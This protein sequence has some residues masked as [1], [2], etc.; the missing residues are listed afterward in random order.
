MLLDLDNL[1]KIGDDLDREYMGT[2]VSNDDPKKLGRVKVSITGLL[3]GSEDELPFAQSYSNPDFF[4]VPN[5]GDKLRIVFKDRDIYSPVY[6]G[7]YHTEVNHNSEFDDDYPNSLGIERDGFKVRYNNN[8]KLLEIITPVGSKITMN[9]DGDIN[10]ESKKDYIVDSD[11]KVTVTSAGDVSITSDSVATFAGKGSTQLGDNSSTT[12]VNGT[13]I[14]LSG[15][16]LPVA[17]VGDKAIGTGNHG[18]PVISTIIAGS[19]KV[20]SG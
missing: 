8:S 7:Y 19:S 9:N 5:V 6:I 16:G 18:A 12:S 2:V 20:F 4:V 14:L 3:E 11:G 13:T 15:G 17:R 10:F 1:I